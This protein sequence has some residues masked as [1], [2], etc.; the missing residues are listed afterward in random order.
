MSSASTG[1]D[2][3]QDWI[4]SYTP[5][6]REACLDILDGNTPEFFVSA[7]RDA[8]RNFSTIVRARISSWKST[9]RSSPVAAGLLS[10]RMSRCLHGEWSAAICTAGALDAGSFTIGWRVF[11]RTVVR[12]LYGYGPFSSCKS[13]SAGKVS[14]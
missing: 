9:E 2:C 4:R 1:G 13:S 10:P 6:D 3:A 11:A 8:L 14:R 5:R 7:D 12:T